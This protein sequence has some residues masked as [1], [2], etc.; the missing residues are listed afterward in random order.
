MF[1]FKC[2]TLGPLKVTKTAYVAME[3]ILF[4]IFFKHKAQCVVNHCHVYLCCCFCTVKKQ[5]RKKKREREGGGG[6]HF[7]ACSGAR[8]A[9]DV[10]ISIYTATG[11]NFF[12]HCYIVTNRGRRKRERERLLSR[13]ATFCNIFWQQSEKNKKN[14]K[15]K[16]EKAKHTKKR[17]DKR[18]KNTTDWTRPG[19]EE[20]KKGINQHRCQ[21]ISP[22]SQDFPAAPQEEK[23]LCVFACCRRRQRQKEKCWGNKPA[24]EHMTCLLLLLHLLPVRPS[25]L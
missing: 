7:P 20:E 6:L 11:K 18:S 13:A 23:T 15:R 17:E 24:A 10:T 1:W 4:F 19:E 12:L 21:R 9:C 5:R 3:T 8:H 22:S 25:V 16:R 2:D 14:K